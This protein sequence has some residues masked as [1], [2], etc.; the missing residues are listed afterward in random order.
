MILFVDLLKNYNLAKWLWFTVNIYYFY[1]LICI[2][3][4]QKNYF[5]KMIGQF[6]IAQVCF[7]IFEFFF[8]LLEDNK[9]LLVRYIK[10]KMLTIL[11][12]ARN[13]M[14]TKTNAAKTIGKY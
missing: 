2:R 4:E 11:S 14:N 8:K 13:M 6:Y 9:R 10:K 5:L 3:L 7:I 1:A 12:T